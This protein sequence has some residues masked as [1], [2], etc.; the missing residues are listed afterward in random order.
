[1]N[2]LRLSASAHQHDDGTKIA[3]SLCPLC[4][5]DVF[6]VPLS[7]LEQMAICVFKDQIIT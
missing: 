4:Q 7:N 6:D 1:M 2:K 3:V 5:V